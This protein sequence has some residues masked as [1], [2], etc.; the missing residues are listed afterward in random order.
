MG[1]DS[2]LSTCVDTQ[3]PKYL[4]MAQGHIS[5]SPK[6]SRSYISSLKNMPNPKSS[7]SAKLSHSGSPKMPRSPAAHGRG[8]RNQT[9]VEMAAVNSKCT[10]SPTSS[11]LL[12][13]LVARNIPP[14]PRKWNSWQGPR[15]RAA[16]APVLLPFP[17][18]R[19]RPPNQRLPRDEGHQRKDGTGATDR[20]P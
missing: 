2:H 12:T 14:G 17:R 10:T 16:A 11:L 8:L 7:T 9:P 1:I 4:E 15:A 5:L 18:R 13:P 20:Q 6:T 3:S 19:L